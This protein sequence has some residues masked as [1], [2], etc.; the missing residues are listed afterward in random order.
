M[1]EMKSKLRKLRLIQFALIAVIPIFG[2]LAEIV[3]YPGS[4]NWTLGHW[5]VTCF[6]LCVAWAG[7]RLRHMLLHRVEQKL[8]MDASNPKALKQ[9]AAVHVCVLAMAENVALC[10]LVVRLVLNGA[11]WQASLFYAGSLILL[12]LWTPRL[13]AE[14]ISNSAPTELPTLPLPNLR[15]ADG[16]VQEVPRKPQSRRVRIAV[17]VALVMGVL[18]IIGG[19]VV[20]I[21]WPTSAV[22][23]VVGLG[24][25]IIETSVII[26]LVRFL[27]SRES[28]STRYLLTIV[29]S[30]ALFYGLAVVAV[31]YFFRGW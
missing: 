12:M 31:G 10:G 22:I 4:N 14:P 24:L 17:V 2:L 19:T 28:L 5:L 25:W 23:V 9:W 8:V 13:T 15:Q 29:I 1:N 3:S 6:A 18:P 21:L 20:G 30:F 16:T 11:L 26:L 7:F 27:G